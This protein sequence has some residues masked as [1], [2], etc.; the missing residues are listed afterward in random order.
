MKIQLYFGGIN[1]DIET[2]RKGLVSILWLEPNDGEEWIKTS[3]K[4]REVQRERSHWKLNEVS[5]TRASAIHFCSPNTPL[6]RFI[7]A[8]WTFI[9]PSQWRSR[10]QIHSGIYQ[11]CSYQF[12][13]S[14]LPPNGSDLTICCCFCVYLHIINPFFYEKKQGNLLSYVTN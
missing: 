5:P 7:C 2:Q 1:N 9:F 14:F 8:A 4:I 13:L 6:F 10:L 11:I 3:A 12:F